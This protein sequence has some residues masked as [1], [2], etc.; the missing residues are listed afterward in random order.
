MAERM[1]ELSPAELDRLE[2]ALEDLERPE[3]AQRWLDD[4]P[5]PHVRARMIEYRDLLIASREAMPMQDVPS[6]TLDDVIAQARSAAAA[7]AVAKASEGSGGS[8]WSRMRRGLLL[9][10][11]A[12]AGTAVLVLWVG[13]P[14]Q[15][16]DVIDAPR[17]PAPD[18]AAAADANAKTERVDAED[19]EAVDADEA[20]A[21]TVEQE[22]TR[23]H[24]GAPQQPA[25]A[26]GSPRARAAA[27]GL[28]AAETRE[29]QDVAGGRYDADADDKPA[30]GKLGSLGE[31]PS[32]AAKS[33]GAAGPE[34]GRWDIISR[35][36]RARQAGDCVTARD[37]YAVAL[38][39]DMAA[40]RARAYA[41][42]G[43]CDAIAGDSPS[44]DSN[45][46]RA[47]ELDG[48]I[49]GF[50]DSQRQRR[51]P[52]RKKRSSKSKKANAIDLDAAA[53]PFG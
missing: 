16:G 7:P 49:D 45:Y 24:D 40:V 46:E 10:V 35:G 25:V 11:V 53:D 15:A 3:A 38:E 29:Q 39:D 32:S 51:A 19:D 26:P 1:P 8:W 30:E 9:P 33:G 21:A 14:D 44:A 37:E 18:A 22:A 28:D 27:T 4:E 12:L 48:S 17:G 31:A 47:R 2:D 42:I 6:G 50:L 5:S 20:A 36:D 23:E 41:G 13:R 34:S 43:L 52:S